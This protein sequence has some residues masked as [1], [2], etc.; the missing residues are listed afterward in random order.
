MT[1]KEKRAEWEK[2]HKTLLEVPIVS[3]GYTVV[4]VVV[5]RPQG[6]VLVRYSLMRYFKVGG[7]WEVSCDMQDVDKLE[8]CLELLSQCLV[9]LYPKE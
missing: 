6:A 5:S 8:T 2:G 3:D 4:Y 9:D 1:L 7:D